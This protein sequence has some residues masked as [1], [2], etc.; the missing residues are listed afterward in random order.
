MEIKATFFADVAI[1]ILFF[2]NEKV[3]PAPNE[4]KYQDF[5]T[6]FVRSWYQHF[7]E[8]FSN[9]EMSRHSATFYRPTAT[10]KAIVI[11]Q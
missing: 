7:L 2:I 5:Q 9:D 10:L 6:E 11:A 3:D 4:W 1:G 8:T